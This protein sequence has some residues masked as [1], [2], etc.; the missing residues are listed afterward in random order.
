MVLN[1]DQEVMPETL[2]QIEEMDNI[3]RVSLIK[4]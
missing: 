1:V 3:L 2:R 4:L